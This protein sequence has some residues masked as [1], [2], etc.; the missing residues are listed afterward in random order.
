MLTKYVLS[1]YGYALS[2]YRDACTFLREH[3]RHPASRKSDTKKE[4]N[5]QAS[6]PAFWL[7]SGGETFPAALTWLWRRKACQL[8]RVHALQLTEAPLASTMAAPNA[9]SHREGS[10]MGEEQ[11]QARETAHDGEQVDEQ[12]AER[13]AKERALHAQRVETARLIAEQLGETGDE[14][15]A[16]IYRAIKKLGIEQALALLQQTHEIEAAGGRTVSDGSRRRTPGGV[17]FLL[18]KE[19]VP[20]ETTK[21]IFKKRSLYEQ[22]AQQKKAVAQAQSQESPAPAAFPPI[23]WEDR[24]ATLKEVH[25]EKGQ[26]TTVK[27]TLIGRPGKLVERGTCI[28]TSMES[29]RVPS[30]PKGLPTPTPAS[31]SY[32]VY[33]ATKQWRKVADSLK[34]QDD[35]LI[36]EGYPHLDTE[37]KTIA[38][39]VTNTTTKNLQAAQR[40]SRQPQQ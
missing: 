3:A 14:P 27:I 5:Q 8:Q 7:Q 37:A 22:A 23:T 25:A 29:T 20:V 32:T 2:Q 36:V 28:I 12:R 33:I 16:Q 15:T 19:H 40:Q 1:Q 38:V 30:L 4:E 31:T 21:H 17:F 35:V 13:K 24:L 6:N 11:Q 18:I 34:D 39:F 26:A 10:H 9:E